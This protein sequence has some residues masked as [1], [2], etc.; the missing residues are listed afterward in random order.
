M[1]KLPPSVCDIFHHS[2]PNV[3]SI[4]SSCLLGTEPSLRPRCSVV[5]VNYTCVQFG[6]ASNVL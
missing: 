4:E 1:L 5:Y 2:Y 3:S 6:P